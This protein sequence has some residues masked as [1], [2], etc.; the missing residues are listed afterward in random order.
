M[1]Y[2]S[3]GSVPTLSDLI[4][5]VDKPKV[6]PAGDLPVKHSH[7]Y[8]KCPYPVIDFYRIADLYKISD[9]NIQHC[10][11][12]LLAAGMRGGGKDIFHDIQ[13]VIDTLTRWQAMRREDELY[14]I[15][16]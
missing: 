7:Y 3:I 2:S 8:R 14:G 1:T 6:K 11:K 10:I 5:G 9:P 12:K 15:D 4:Q 13:D 16:R